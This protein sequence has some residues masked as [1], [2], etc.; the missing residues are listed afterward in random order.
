MLRARAG[1]N[2]EKS[3]LRIDVSASNCPINKNRQVLGSIAVFDPQQPWPE[4]LMAVFGFVGIALV[5]FGAGW[6]VGTTLVQWKW[7]GA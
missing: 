2:C 3:Q 4:R 6:L 1:L 5:A 7:F